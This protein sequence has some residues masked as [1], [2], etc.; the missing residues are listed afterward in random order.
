MIYDDGRCCA[1]PEYLRAYIPRK[2]FR[3]KYCTK[4]GSLILD[5]VWFINILYKYVFEPFWNGTYT[6]IFDE[7]VE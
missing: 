7:K 6:V 3:A 2:L 5:E 1:Y 4:C